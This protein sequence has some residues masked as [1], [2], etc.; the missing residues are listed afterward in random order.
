MYSE[1]LA[2][3]STRSTPTSSSATRY[4]RFA[5]S[6][7]PPG[8]GNSAMSGVYHQIPSEFEFPAQSYLSLGN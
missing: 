2:L 5:A 1:K 6:T 4:P 8:C 7:T 3:Y